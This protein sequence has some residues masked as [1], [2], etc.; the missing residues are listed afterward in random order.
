M[1]ILAIAT[2]SIL[3]CCGCI[4]CMYQATNIHR[5]AAPEIQEYARTCSEVSSKLLQENCLSRRI[6]STV[7]EQTGWLTVFNGADASAQG[8]AIGPFGIH[9]DDAYTLTPGVR[10]AVAHEVGHQRRLDFLRMLRP[11][12]RRKSIPKIECLTEDLAIQISAELNDQETIDHHIKSILKS[13]PRDGLDYYFV[14][15]FNGVANAGLLAAKRGLIR[16]GFERLRRQEDW[17]CPC[18]HCNIAQLDQR[19]G[20]PSE[21]DLRGCLIE[22]EVLNWT[23]RTLTEAADWR[24]EA[25][26]PLRGQMHI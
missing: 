12:R 18:Q 3:G 1:T 15:T 5:L 19:D 17:Q 8:Y 14:G 25:T 24:Q 9:L 13:I 4:P 26:A 20:N 11:S 16:A 7:L 23:P 2:I 22:R 10:H 6:K 21:S